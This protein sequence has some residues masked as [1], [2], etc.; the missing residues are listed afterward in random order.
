MLSRSPVQHVWPEP[1][2]QPRIRYVGSLETEEDIQKKLSFLEG[3]DELIFGRKETGV[4]RAPSAVAVSPQGKLYV[5]DS[6]AGVIHC[7]DFES[8]SYLQFGKLRG[9]SRLQR[10]MALTLVGDMIYVVDS[11]LGRVCVFRPDGECMAMF[12][13]AHLKRPV[14]IAYHP[15]RKIIYIADTGD[16][17]LKLFQ[18]SGQFVETL[19][20]RG[21]GPGQFNFPTYLW[22]DSIGNLFISDTLNYRIQILSSTGQSFT[23]FGEHGDRPGYFGHPSGV[24]TDQHGHI[25]VTDRQFENVQIFDSYGRILMAF[26]NEGRG[27]GEFWLPSGIFIDDHNWIYVA[28]TFNKRIQIFEFLESANYG[29]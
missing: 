17:N 19:G 9:N 24:A 10:P 4:L 14:G 23:T 15:A 12:G 25:Y 26:G 28:D 8:K 29:N 3:L 27:P 2:Q 1:P 5:A 16:H 20:S 21:T 18:P 11:Q 13:E 7:F 22:L 6:A